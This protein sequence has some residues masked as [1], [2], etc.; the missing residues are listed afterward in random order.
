M[1]KGDPRQYQ[2]GSGFLFLIQSFVDRG[3]DCR[4]GCLANLP[5][6]IILHKDRMSSHN[7]YLARISSD[8]NRRWKKQPTVKKFCGHDSFSNESFFVSHE[9]AVFPIGCGTCKE[10]L[11]GTSTA[12]NDVT[13]THNERTPFTYRF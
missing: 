1:G 4:G 6:S 9:C 3:D 5:A 7:M 13:V 12:T 10:T 11:N 8:Q 2:A